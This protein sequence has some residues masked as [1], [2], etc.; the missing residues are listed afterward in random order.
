M[1]IWNNLQKKNTSQVWN[2]C[3]WFLAKF[4][5]KLLSKLSVGQIILPPLLHTKWSSS[6]EH[7]FN[8]KCQSHMT[9]CDGTYFVPHLKLVNH[10]PIPS[11]FN[12]ALN[13]LGQC[14]CIYWDGWQ[15]HCHWV[16]QC[17]KAAYEGCWHESAP[18]VHKFPNIGHYHQPDRDRITQDY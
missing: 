12:L 14:T 2:H 17:V 1:E 18:V 7:L 4:Q 9:Y 11:N 8:S 3:T 15:G 10:P 16:L 6:W 5:L 13:H